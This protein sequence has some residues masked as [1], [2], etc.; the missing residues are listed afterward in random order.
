MPDRDWWSVLWPDPEA[1]LR[2]LGVASGMT[3][4][5]LCCGDGYFTAP[6]ARITGGRTYGV[7]LYPEVLDKARAELERA[8]V[9][10]RDLICGDARDLPALLPEKASYV[11]ISNTFHG[12]PDRT[13]IARAVASVLVRGGRFAV[14][15]WHRQPRESTVVLGSP[16]GPET[17]MRMT[18]EDV[19]RAVQ[20]AGF[21]TERVVEL[22]PYHYGA[23]FRLSGGPAALA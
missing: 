9:A 15:N 22:P 12:V 19:E 21:A 4:V 17:W 6:L 7:D 18:P 2:K 13:A 8:G 20:P 5:D 16:R 1:V 10:A 14:I 11:L 3:V 23:V